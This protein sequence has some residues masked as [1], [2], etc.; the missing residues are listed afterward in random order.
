M[1]AKRSTVLVEGP[2]VLRGL[3][4]QKSWEDH[5]N[6]KRLTQS[7]AAH[8]KLANVSE[9]IGGLKTNSHLGTQIIHT[10]E[11][12][13]KMMGGNLESETVFIIYQHLSFL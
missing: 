6:Q 13:K 2:H 10:Q 9:E 12:K 4:D 8:M 11:K 1:A 3:S 5:E 7:S